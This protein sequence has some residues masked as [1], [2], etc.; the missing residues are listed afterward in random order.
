MTSGGLKEILESEKKAR[1]IMRQAHEEAERIR[2]EAMKAHHEKVDAVQQELD[3]K[4]DQRRAETQARAAEMR[5]TVLAEAERDVLAWRSR[6]EE[7]ESQI[8][9]AVRRIVTDGIRGSR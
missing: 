4:R 2:Q 8:A 7:R 1:E 3:R 6:Y 5:K 9:A